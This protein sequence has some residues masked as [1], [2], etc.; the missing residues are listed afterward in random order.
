MSDFNVNNNQIRF[1]RK[2]GNRL[3]SDSVFC[4]TCGTKVA[5]HNKTENILL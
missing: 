2:C 4:E 1:C 3:L 5:E